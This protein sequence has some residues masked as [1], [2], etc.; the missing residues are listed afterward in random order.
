VGWYDTDA[1]SGGTAISAAT[2]VSVDRTVY[3]R[4]NDLLVQFLFANRSSTTYAN[5]A[6][7]GITQTITGTITG[8]NSANRY[9]S[10]VHGAKTFYY[11][12]N[13]TGGSAMYLNMG[14]A[15]T[16]GAVIGSLNEEFTLATYLFIQTT[17]TTKGSAGN[18]AASFWNGTPGQTA[19][20]LMYLHTKDND[21]GY[22]ITLTGWGSSAEKYVKD[23]ATN[24]LT[25]GAWHHIAYTQTGKTETNNGKLYIDGVLVKEG[26]IPLL[27]SDLGAT[28]NNRLGGVPYSGDNG[29]NYTRYT[30]FRLYC[31]AL[32]A[33]EITAAFMP[34]L[35]LLQQ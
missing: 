12:S 28:A 27:P 6:G 18:M 23:T 26:T 31:R 17:S 24:R 35:V 29:Q 20:Q 8:T 34:D 13:Y 10:E 32:S 3:A 33:D 11:Y 21:E 9:G 5:N 2:V 22:A 19:G 1:A 14:N 16:M 4:W 7:A 30:D 15:T 25:A